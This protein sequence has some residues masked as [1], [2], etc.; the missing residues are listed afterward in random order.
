MSRRN[1]A[2]PV[3]LD[4]EPAEVQENRNLFQRAKRDMEDIKFDFEVTEK[5]EAAWQK[6][7]VD[8]KKQCLANTIRMFVMRGSCMF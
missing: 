3:E 2:A 1:K 4:E 5:E 6:V 7:D 8:K